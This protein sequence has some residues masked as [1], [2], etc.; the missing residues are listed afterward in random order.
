MLFKLILNWEKT[1]EG[2]KKNNL[3]SVEKY[4]TF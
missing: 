3:L 2:G 4:D 1:S